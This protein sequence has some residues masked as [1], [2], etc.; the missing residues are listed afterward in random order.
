M[1]AAVSAAAR[2]GVRMTVLVLGDDAKTNGAAL[3]APTNGEAQS[4]A[5]QGAHARVR[6]LETQLQASAKALAQAQAAV[7]AAAAGDSGMALK[8]LQDQLAAA[9]AE[10]AALKA[11]AQTPAPPAPPQAAGGTPGDAVALDSLGLDRLGLDEKIT[12]ALNNAGLIT[13]GA[14]RT[15][16]LAEPS[17]YGTVKGLNKDQC[18]AIGMALLR[19]VPSSGGASPGP[20]VAAKPGSGSSD[21]TL[22]TGHAD[23]PWRARFDSALSKE[24]RH[25]VTDAAI[26]ESLDK[27]KAAHP[28]VIDKDG[29]VNYGL[30]AQKDAALFT[31]L[32]ED[33]MTLAVSRGQMIAMLWGCNLPIDCSVADALTKANVTLPVVAPA[34]PPAAPTPAP[35][36]VATA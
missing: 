21:A 12:K 14:V 3:A 25:K 5:L 11:A 22:P 34:T 9:Q 29:R 24:N 7:P 15:A 10:V 19:N 36:P 33:E 2:A 27:I 28:D 32:R 20:V 23:R 6:D 16:Y 18:G 8:A 26:K 1:E 31:K 35:A 13:V 4:A 30:L 17:I